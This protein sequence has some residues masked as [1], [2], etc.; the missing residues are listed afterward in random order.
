[1][2]RKTKVEYIMYQQKPKEKEENYFYP[3]KFEVI[4]ATEHYKETNYFCK[5]FGVSKTGSFLASSK[6]CR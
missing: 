4:D 3:T 1:V 6:R 5:V 2:T